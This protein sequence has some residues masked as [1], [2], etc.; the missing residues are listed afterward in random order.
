M[1]IINHPYWSKVEYDQILP[2]KRLMGVEVFNYCSYVLENV[3]EA[4]ACWDALLRNGMRLWG[5]AVDDTHN[6]FPIESGG[7]DAFGGYIMVKAR[8]LTQD[9]LMEAI[10]A[11]SFYG[12]AGPEIKEFYVEDGMV[13][14]TCSPVSRIFF[15]GHQRQIRFKWAEPGEQLTELVY[16]LYGDTKYGEREKYIRAECYDAQ[17]RKA[18]TNPIWLD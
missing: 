6:F 1:V 2:L 11:G 5:T 16:P 10:A 12:T 7:N 15:N 13:H 4:Y 8:S 17:G 9:D 3:G 14:F 18:F